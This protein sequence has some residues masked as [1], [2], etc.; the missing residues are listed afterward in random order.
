M[1]K[2]DLIEKVIGLIIIIIIII[3]SWELDRV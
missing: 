2:F 3:R 1:P